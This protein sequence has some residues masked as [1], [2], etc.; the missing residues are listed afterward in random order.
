MTNKPQGKGIDERIQAVTVLEIDLA[1][2][3]WAAKSIAVVGN[4]TYDP[5]QK[6]PVA[7]AV[8]G[9]I[10]WTKAQGVEQGNG[11]RPHGKDIAQ[12]TADAGGSPLKG[13]NE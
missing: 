10:K 13:L 12:N 3:G 2:D 6:R 7:R 9:C 4:S 8:P 5:V 1:T 11:T